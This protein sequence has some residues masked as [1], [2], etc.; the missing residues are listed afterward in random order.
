MN[1]Q[2]PRLP[3]RTAVSAHRLVLR[4]ATAGLGIPDD[5]RLRLLRRRLH[6]ALSQLLQVS[7]ALS[8]FLWLS[9]GGLLAGLSPV[10]RLLVHSSR[11]FQQRLMGRIFHSDCAAVNTLVQAHACC[12]ATGFAQ[13]VTVA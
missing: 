3:T 9:S 7:R 12:L 10:H 4:P 8:Q 6:V 2:T 5:G 11:W 13:G 1:N